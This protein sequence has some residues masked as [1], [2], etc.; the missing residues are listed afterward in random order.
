MWYSFISIKLQFSK[1]YILERWNLLSV[2]YNFGVAE[3][4]CVP[5]GTIRPFRGAKQSTSKI[6]VKTIWNVS[7]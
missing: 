7:N 6:S 1:I 4:S 3:L 2:A 5:K